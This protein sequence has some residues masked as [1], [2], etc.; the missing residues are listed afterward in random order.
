MAKDKFAQWMQM[1]KATQAVADTLIGV[2][3]ITPCS[4]SNQLLMA[5]HRVELM[6]GDLNSIPADSWIATFI[7]TRPDL[8]LADLMPGSPYLIAWQEICGERVGAAG[9]A[10][11][12]NNQ[13]QNFPVPFL[14]AHPKLYLYATSANTGLAQ[15][16]RARLL[17]TLE[18]VST[19]EFFQA[20][21]EYGE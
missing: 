8:A 15:T 2:E 17:F 3:T 20:L 4:P 21:T 12:E 16:V 7:A 14:V 5:I 18:K 1:N 19:E 10:T 13:C 6:M 9:I 11:Y